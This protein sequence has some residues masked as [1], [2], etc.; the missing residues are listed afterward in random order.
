MSCFSLAWVEQLLIW[1]VVVIAV[2]AIFRLIVPWLMGLIGAPPGGGMIITILG[3]IVWAVVVIAVVIFV[4][5]LI[6]CALGGTR[7]I[8]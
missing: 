4:F 2:I 7:L 6:S 1:V 5:D 8:R 3:Y